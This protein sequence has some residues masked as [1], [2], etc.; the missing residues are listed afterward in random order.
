M[1]SSDAGR[2]RCE[3]SADCGGSILSFEFSSKPLFIVMF[4]WFEGSADCGSSL[5]S[6]WF[7]SEPLWAKGIFLAM[8]SMV[9]QGETNASTNVKSDIMAPR[10]PV[11]AR[12]KIVEVGSTNNSS[13]EKHEISEVDTLNANI[14]FLGE[15]GWT[16]LRQVPVKNVAKGKNSH[17][18]LANICKGMATDSTRVQ[19]KMVPA[20]PPV[21][22]KG[23]HIKIG[24]TSHSADKK[25]KD[26]RI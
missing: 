6:F 10:V 7:S 1:S 15:S 20:E 5:P 11:I 3:G 14:I 23:K 17:P 8:P 22:A 24:S 12:K 13:R 16:R 4:C 26:L 21:R 9:S 19:P 2:F 18:T 25:T